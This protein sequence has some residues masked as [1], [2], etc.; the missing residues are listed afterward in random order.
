[1]SF[2]LSLCCYNEHNENG[3][4]SELTK[5]CIQ[6]ICRQNTG[7]VWEAGMIFQ[8][9]MKLTIENALKSLLEEM[10]LKAITV[11]K[12]IDRCGCSRATFYYHF[13]DKYQVILSIY[14]RMF[15]AAYHQYPSITMKQMIT[16]HY[17]SLEDHLA[18]ARK[19]LDY[20]EQG[21]VIKGLINYAVSNYEEMLMKNQNICEINEDLGFQIRFHS[22]ASIGTMAFWVVN[23]N[24]EKPEKVAEKLLRAM[25]Q[26]LYN[27]L[28][29]LI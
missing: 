24:R 25:P 10:P 13:T 6:L 15:N 20:D 5:I 16:A 29:N 17:Q 21:P 23:D 12:I 11:Q 26:E 22:I 18:F 7:F 2:F 3:L 28:D 8:E 27:S 19:T 1:M 4:Y 14:E 9:R